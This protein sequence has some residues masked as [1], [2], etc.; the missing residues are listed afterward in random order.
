MKSLKYFFSLLLIASVVC[1]VSCKKDPP[2]DTPIIKVNYPE[3]PKVDGKV[4][5]FAKFEK[6]VC[7]NGVVALAGSYKLKAGSESAWSENPAELLKFTS[8]G[9]IDGKD[10][11]AEGWWKV[12]VDVPH[13]AGGMEGNILGIKPVHLIANSKFDWMFQVGDQV[14]IKSGQVELKPGFPGEV[15]I[16]LMTNETAAL[17]F[18]S[19]KND[20]CAVVVRNYTFSVT[21]PEGTPADAEVFIAGGMNG[22]D[23]TASKLTKGSNGKYSITINNVIEGTEYKYV[24]NG[25][26]DNEEMA[27]DTEGTGCAPGISNRKTGSNTAIS[28]VVEN[29]KGITTC[30][31][32][33]YP[34]APAENGKITIFA[35]FDAE[36]CDEIVMMGSHIGWNPDNITAETKFVSAGTI[37]DTDWG[38][39]GWYKVTIPYSSDLNAKPVQLQDGKFFWDFQVGFDV[40]GDIV[41]KSGGAQPKSRGEDGPGECDIKFISNTT[42]ALIF[43]KWKHDPCVVVPKHEITFSVKLPASTPDNAVVR[44]VGGFGS[45][46]YPDWKQADDAMKLTKVGDKY[47]IKL[48]L[49]EG[50]VE[51]KYVLNGDWANEEYNANCEKA[52]PTN[53]K[54]E[55][56]ADAT[57][58]DEVINWPGLGACAPLIPP[59][60]FLFNL[61]KFTIISEGQ[62][63]SQRGWNVVPDVRAA[64]ANGSIKYFVIAFEAKSIEARGGLGGFEMIVNCAA[65]NWSQ[66][67]NAFGWGDWINYSDLIAKDYAKL[68]NGI[69]YLKYD[70]TTHV[71][72]ADFKAGMA[73]ATWAQ[74]MIQIWEQLDVVNVV[75]GFFCGEKPF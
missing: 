74:W 18:K 22:W 41:V 13:P 66:H 7:T 68:D 20:P 26:W 9:V 42:A 69:L 49:K 29:W 36:V 39:E 11:G 67:G 5:I 62:P 6:G 70:V 16:F 10:W 43:K 15:D 3:A 28:D 24:L 60:E 27:A 61:G 40:E 58:N 64:F 14:E 2:V 53:R 32:P 33:D 50:N 35:K 47:T 73:S 57:V 51:Y 38:A 12:V 75:S 1:M 17:I 30:L 63:R 56:K 65:T 8:A 45:S 21:V 54:Y 19:W 25:S 31:V 23:Q 48:N 52:Y 37:G 71:K 55:V 46:G 72:F 59:F 34:T 44:I 4:T